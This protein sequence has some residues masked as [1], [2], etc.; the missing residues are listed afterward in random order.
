[1]NGPTR[2]LPGS[3]F[4]D[5]GC[6][7]D[8][9]ITVMIT[10]SCPCD[11]DN[12]DNQKWCCGDKTHLDLSHS[13]FGLIANHSKGVVDIKY[14]R[15]ESCGAAEHSVNMQTCDN[16]EDYHTAYY[17]ADVCQVF[18][19][20]AVSFAAAGVVLVYLVVG[21]WRKVRTMSRASSQQHLNEC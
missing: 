20:A 1:M 7:S 11:H 15:L 17:V 4:E 13:A 9:T 14:T 6:I 5:S 16:F 12:P 18:F 19:G 8:Q 3:E 2:G 10:D 21:L